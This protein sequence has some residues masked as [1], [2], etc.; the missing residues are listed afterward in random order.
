[1]FIKISYAK[2]DDGTKRCTYEIVKSYREKGNK[3]PTHK[4]I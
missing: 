3:N 2:N 4:V 1:M